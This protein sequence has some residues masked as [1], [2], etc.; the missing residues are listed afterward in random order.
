MSVQIHEMTVLER[1][2]ERT[3]SHPDAVRVHLNK[4]QAA[5]LVVRLTAQLAEDKEEI[6]VTHFGELD[7]PN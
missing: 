1:K 5:D 3:K 6:M 2:G 7:Q 4:A